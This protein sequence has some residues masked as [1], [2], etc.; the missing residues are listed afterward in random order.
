MG[1]HV[2][3]VSGFRT[4]SNFVSLFLGARLA[5]IAL[6]ELQTQIKKLNARIAKLEKMLNGGNA[7][8]DTIICNRWM[9]VDKDGKLRIRAVTFA[10]GDAGVE[11]FDK[12][13]KVRIAASTF[14][15]GQAAVKCLDNNEMERMTALTRANGKASVQL[16][17]KDGYGRIYAG[18]RADGDPILTCCDKDEEFRIVKP[19]VKP[20][21]TPVVTPVFDPFLGWSVKTF[22]TPSPQQWE[23]P[24]KPKKP[25]KPKE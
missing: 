7:T 24:K 8:F 12:D 11:L 21:V 19:V 18:T 4:G 10:D 16:Y 3:D 6:M 23:P 5:Y 15:D 14:A 20:V 25:K 9:V 2:L 13:E 22:R 1:F 17:D